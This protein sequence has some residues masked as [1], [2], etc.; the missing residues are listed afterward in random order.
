[1]TADAARRVRLSRDRW[2]F[3]H[4]PI[5]CI[6]EARGGSDA[7]AAALADAW[8]CFSTC[9]GQIVQDLL[10][11]RLNLS[12]ATAALGNVSS[13]PIARRMISA[14]LPHATHGRFITAMAAIAGSV[15]EELIAY[16]DRPGITRAW[17]NNGGDIALYLA[18]GSS[19]TI[20]T[21]A[22]LSLA[23]AGHAPE[24]R[25][26]VDASSPVR[27]IATSGWRGRSF[28]LGIADAVTILAP[29]ASVADAAATVVA[30]AV[31]IDAPGI[32]RRPAND[33]RD[34]SDLGDRLVTV[35]VPPLSARDV[36]AAL[37]AGLRQAEHEIAAGRIVAAIL[38]LQGRIRVCGNIAV[39]HP[40]L[41]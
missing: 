32:L 26:T 18:P 11:L 38:Q 21:V 17:V 1:M 15:A 12:S 19:V 37:D 20:G 6:V 30:N 35:G 40:L 29:T 9:L 13:G 28:S 8:Q 14:C 22:D 31:D 10:F 39:S 34:D 25:F 27:G 24:G 7:V 5:D 2:H 36:D 23:Y 3:Q 41:G 4:G 16:F 33:V